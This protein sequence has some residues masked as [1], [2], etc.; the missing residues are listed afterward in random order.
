M[1]D[2]AND[3]LGRSWV[4]TRDSA[5]LLSPVTGVVR[6]CVTLSVPMPILAAA[7]FDGGMLI[8]GGEGLHVVDPS[9]G[10][11]LDTVVA[12]QQFGAIEDV[13]I[14]GTELWFTSAELGSDVLHRYSLNS[15]TE[16]QTISMGFRGAKGLIVHD[17]QP[18]VFTETG[19]RVEFSLDGG[20]RATRMVGSWVGAADPP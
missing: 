8:V 16:L 6:N 3:T 9:T 4:T 5:C 14:S 20:S 10:A 19:F 12:A 2:I 7:G 15:R 17:G 18:V 11:R 1:T 13:A